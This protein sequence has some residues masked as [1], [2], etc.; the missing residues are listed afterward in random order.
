MLLGTLV[1]FA[2]SHP[3]GYE[4]V[5]NCGFDLLFPSDS[6]VEMSI[7]VLYRLLNRLFCCH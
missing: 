4:V 2:S 3:N 1:F 5:S 7:Q 6:D